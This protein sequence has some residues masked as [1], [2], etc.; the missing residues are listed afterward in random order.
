MNRSPVEQ[1]VDPLLNQALQA[2][3]RAAVQARRVAAQ[4][5]TAIVVLENGQLR[6]VFPNAVHEVSPE[7]HTDK[8][9]PND[10]Q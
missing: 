1:T 4:T 2:M 9:K 7:Y 5:G 8:D 6:R 10:G 3:N